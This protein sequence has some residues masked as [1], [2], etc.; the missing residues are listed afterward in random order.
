ML[1]SLQMLKDFLGG[2]WRRVPIVLRRRMM[3]LTQTRF[4]V[5]AAAIVVDENNRALLLKHRFRPGKGWGIPGGFVEA[6]EHPDEAV[7]RELLE[8]IGLEVED[9]QLFS[10][11]T[12]KPAKQIEILFRCRPKGSPTPKSIEIIKAVWCSADELP[13]QLPDGQHEMIKAALKDGA[14]AS[15]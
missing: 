5:T 14:N 11:R 2:L 7:R 8:E 4:T 9:L 3:R 1:F 15:S 6:H 12:F 10:T 13:E